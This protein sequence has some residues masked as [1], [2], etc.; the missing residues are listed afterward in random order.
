LHVENI[1]AA[2]D[3]IGRSEE[4]LFKNAPYWRGHTSWHFAVK[5]R[6]VMFFCLH[7]CAKQCQCH[8]MWINVVCCSWRKTIQRSMP[9]TWCEVPSMVKYTSVTC[10]Q[11]C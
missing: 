3:F 1:I 5:D 6:P 4:P 7:Y 10:I 2:I 9:S 8:W 11:C